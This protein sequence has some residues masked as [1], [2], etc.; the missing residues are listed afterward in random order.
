MIARFEASRKQLAEPSE[1]SCRDLESSEQ[2]L[3]LLGD[4]TSV[5]LAVGISRC[6]SD[7][8]FPTQAKRWLDRSEPEA[9]A[10]QLPFIRVEF[11]LAHAAV[12]LG[13][14]RWSEADEVLQAAAAECRRV[15]LG[16]HLMET[17][18]LEARLALARGDHPERVRTLAEE[19]ER[20]AN[21]GRFGRIA[22]EA[23]EILRAPRL[24][25]G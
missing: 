25:R 4:R 17:R 21:A 14:R 24:A 16:Y 23:G 1:R 5:E 9:T 3:S 15:S 6:W 11:E 10:S 20:D 12:A 8:G 7:A 2:E 19:L 18:L 13:T 22:R